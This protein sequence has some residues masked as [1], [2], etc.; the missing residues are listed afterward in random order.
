MIGETVNR[1]W[2]SWIVEV[3]DHVADF[4]EILA[5]AGWIQPERHDVVDTVETDEGIVEGLGNLVAVGGDILESTAEEAGANPTGV[6][7]DVKPEFVVIGGVA[8]FKVEA[9]KAE[10]AA[11]VGI[12]V[13]V[14]IGVGKHEG[15]D[16]FGGDVARDFGGADD[17]SVIRSGRGEELGLECGIAG[18]H[19]KTATAVVIESKK[20]IGGGQD[21]GLRGLN[22]SGEKRVPVG[23]GFVAELCALDCI[24]DLGW[25]RA[26]G[27][28]GY[29]EDRPVHEGLNERIG[30]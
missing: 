28:I 23:P 2:K 4:E 7:H 21:H 1:D 19:E 22:I 8:G 18:Q 24:R 6:I 9:V 16:V 10:N 13:L 27:V 3:L 20:E 30:Q 11:L 5:L 15:G 17:G 14:E 12:V 25:A 29:A 26:A